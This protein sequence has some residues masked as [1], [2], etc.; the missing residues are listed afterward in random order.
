MEEALFSCS[1]FENI[2]HFLIEDLNSS[3]TSALQ[4]GLR[5]C[6]N[7]LTL[8]KMVIINVFCIISLKDF[9]FTDAH[10]MTSTCKS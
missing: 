6:V 7:S 5:E 4:V 2:F 3:E 10:V 1:A 9:M 8:N